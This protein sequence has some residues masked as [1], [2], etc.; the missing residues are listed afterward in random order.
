[1]HYPFDK[2]IKHI[3]AA[4]QV[5]VM[6]IAYIDSSRHPQCN[7]PTRVTIKPMEKSLVH[8]WTNLETQFE[9]RC[10]YHSKDHHTIPIAA[11]SL[12]REKNLYRSSA[13]N[14]RLTKPEKQK[15]KN[16]KN[17]LPHSQLVG[18]QKRV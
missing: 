4:F 9:P 15:N 18:S 12:R 14:Y 8:F 7:A 10:L 5:L 17:C 3:S 1:M 16:H 13:L 2:D 11:E 6:R